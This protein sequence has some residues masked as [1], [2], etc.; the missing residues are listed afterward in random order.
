MFD[1]PP[2]CRRFGARPIDFWAADRYA[3]DKPPA[4]GIYTNPKQRICGRFR[5][6]RDGVK[7]VVTTSKIGRQICIDTIGRR[8]VGQLGAFVR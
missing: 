1:K 7:P 8:L 5:R 4:N 2:A 6:G 3:R